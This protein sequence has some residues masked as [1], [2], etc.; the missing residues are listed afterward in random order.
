MNSNAALIDQIAAQQ[1]P[2]ITMPHDASAFQLLQEPGQR[3]IVAA[4][5]LFKEV[6]RPWLHAIVPTQPLGTGVFGRPA[7]PYGV[8]EPAVWLKFAIPPH[9]LE[10]FEANARRAMPLE[11]AAWMIWDEDTDALTLMELPMSQQTTV[12]CEIQRPQLRPNQHL[13]LDMHSHH[14]MEAEF[15]HTDDMDDAGSGEVKLA[16]VIGEMNRIPR[17]NFRLCVEGLLID[18]FHDFLKIG[19]LP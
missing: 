6:R 10:A 11:V 16:A 18:D 8:L 9:I 2:V 19:A 13:V 12:L 17:W 1:C 3:L 4:H 5:G 15:S 14:V 7:T